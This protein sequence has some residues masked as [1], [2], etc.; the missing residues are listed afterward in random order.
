MDF[1]TYYTLANV[2]SANN[3]YYGNEVIVI[4]EGLSRTTWHRTTWHRQYLKR[5]ILYSH[6]AKGK[7]NEEFL[8]IIRANNNTMRSDI[9]CAYWINFTK[10]HNIGSLLGF[11]IA[12]W[13]RDNGKSATWSRMRT[14]TTDACTQCTTNFRRA[15]CR[16]IKYRK[17]RR[18]SQV[19][20]LIIVRSITDLTIHV[21]DQDS[22]LLNFC[23]KRS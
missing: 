4:P 2:N 19:Y 22:R 7:K 21:V 18:R 17:G 16:D 5:E 3:F 15:C 1:E 20:F 23:D 10:P 14:A 12:C 6:D 11:R 9:K 13:S 8:L